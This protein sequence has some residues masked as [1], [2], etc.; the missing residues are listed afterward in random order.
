MMQIHRATEDDCTCSQDITRIKHL[1]I[2]G[3]CHKMI[4]QKAPAVTRV[5]FK[6]GLAIYDNSNIEIGP[7]DCT[8]S[9]KTGS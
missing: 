8:C 4:S 6:Q 3:I 2:R 7:I 9:D 1:I 5:Y